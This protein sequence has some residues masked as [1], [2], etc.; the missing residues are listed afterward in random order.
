MFEI[1]LKSVGRGAN[2]ILNVPPDGRGLITKYD[3]ASLMGFK[4]LREES[5]GGDL[6][7]SVRQYFVSNREKSITRDLDNK[8]ENYF[9]PIT[10]PETQS[11]GIDYNEPTKIN[12][13]VLKENLIDG[14]NCAKFTIRLF[15]KN[16]DAINE[17]SGTTIGHKR[18]LTFPEE[19]VS[20]LRFS[21]DEQKYPTKISSIKTY[22]IDGKLV[23]K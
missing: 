7:K 10:N 4:K 9:E 14:Q 19:E 3:S 23:I 11:I 5:F 12:C 21:V 8:N 18:I 13:I 16:G 2:L 17:I 20:S 15:G 22:L 6:S 1:Y